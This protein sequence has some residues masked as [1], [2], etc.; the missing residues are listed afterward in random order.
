MLQLRLAADL[1]IRMV[2]AGW[3]WLC[4]L[5][6]FRL[7]HS[8]SHSVRV[9]V[10]VRARPERPREG[11]FAV[12]PGQY[13]RETELLEDIAKKEGVEA[14]LAIVL[15]WHTDQHQVRAAGLRRRRRCRRW[16][17]ISEMEQGSSM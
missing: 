12:W 9:A 2:R 3:G 5:S 8:T 14:G 7:P 1:P 6:I 15:S 17:G 10:V 13:L 16:M 4:G 11:M